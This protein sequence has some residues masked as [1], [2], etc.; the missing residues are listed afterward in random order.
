MESPKQSYRFRPLTDEQSHCIITIFASESVKVK[1]IDDR[2]CHN[3]AR[4]DIHNL[5]LYRPNLS[6]EVELC[7]NFYNTELGILASCISSQEIKKGKVSYE[8]FPTA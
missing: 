2:G 8:F 6:R 4:V 1:Y 3:R 5:P 7:I